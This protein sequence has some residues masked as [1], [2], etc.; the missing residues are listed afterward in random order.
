MGVY[1][2]INSYNDCSE[3][4]YSKRESLLSDPEAMQFVPA[5]SSPTGKDILISVG[6]VSGSLHVFE[7]VDED[8]KDYCAP[9]PSPPSPPAPPPDVVLLELVF[10]ST[11]LTDFAEGSDNYNTVKT[12]VATEAV[13]PEG[14][15]ALEF[16]LGSVISTAAITVPS[17][18]NASQITTNLNTNFGT[19]AAATTLLSLPGIAVEQ[20]PS[21]V[22]ASPPPP[23][24]SVLGG[25]AIAGIVVGV[26]LAVSII[27]VA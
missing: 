1:L 22:I 26:L 9:P 12:K 10:D 23:S 11:S 21:V 25:G 14:N 17:T 24:K 8:A 5:A 13:V 7:V 20:V 4:D 15:V 6:A 3:T 2:S 16:T 27:I 18:T 19:A